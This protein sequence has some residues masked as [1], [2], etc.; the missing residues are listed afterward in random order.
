MMFLRTDGTACL[1]EVANETKNINNDEQVDQA[2]RPIVT[3]FN[4]VN[5]P[6]AVSSLL[7]SGETVS[8]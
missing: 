2:N 7:L 1:R 6:V 8:F 4:R 3:F 5:V